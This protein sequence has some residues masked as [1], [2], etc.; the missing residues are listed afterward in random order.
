MFV[1]FATASLCVA[2]QTGSVVRAG[3]GKGP[4]GQHGSRE[5]RSVHREDRVTVQER[6]RGSR[7]EADWKT[8]K[9][10]RLMFRNNRKKKK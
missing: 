9:E 3:Q 6:A 1:F 7:K 2:A 4:G 8:V 10:Y 5:R